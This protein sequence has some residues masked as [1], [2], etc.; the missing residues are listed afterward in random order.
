MIKTLEQIGVKPLSGKSLSPDIR[1]LNNILY[2]YG[3]TPTSKSKAIEILDMLTT[4]KKTNQMSD[5]QVYINRLNDYVLNFRFE[6]SDKDTIQR[7]INYLVARYIKTDRNENLFDNI[8]RWRYTKSVITEYVTEF[9]N[10]VL[11][12]KSFDKMK[13]ELISMLFD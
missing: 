2:Q 6:E 1:K 8:I 11:N 7:M 3:A 9:P 5:I 10:C 4:V 13:D 12:R